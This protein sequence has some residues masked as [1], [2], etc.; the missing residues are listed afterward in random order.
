MYEINDAVTLPP[1]PGTAAALFIG[2]AGSFKYASGTPGAGEGRTSLVLAAGLAAVG[3]AVLPLTI[4]VIVIV[5]VVPVVAAVVATV[6]ARVAVAAG[7]ARTTVDAGGGVGALVPPQAA[8][9][10]LPAAMAA[11]LRDAWSSARADPRRACKT[12]DSLDSAW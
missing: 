10:A 3:A 11:P 7:D 6:L 4:E 1:L 9:S 2:V 5:G 8:R 12:W